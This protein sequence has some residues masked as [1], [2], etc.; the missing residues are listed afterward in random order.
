MLDPRLQ[1]LANRINQLVN[2]SP[3]TMAD[4]ARLIGVDRSAVSRW[5]TGAR[6]PTVQNLVDLAAVLQV[7]VRELWDGPEAVP[8]TP[9][10]KAMI[11]RMGAM[12]PEQQ[13]AF[14]ALAESMFRPR[15]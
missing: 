9:E 8:A 7:E 4:I 5:L 12:T 2:G 6:T 3:Y 13:Q 11:E 10:Q 14:L 1:K 15:S